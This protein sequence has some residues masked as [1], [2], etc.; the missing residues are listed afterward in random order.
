ML[1]LNAGIV[2]SCSIVIVV[3]FCSVLF[4]VCVV[5]GYCLVVVFLGDVM[6]FEVMY[7]YVGSGCRDRNYFYNYL[8]VPVYV[9]LCLS[10]FLSL[11]FLGFED[12]T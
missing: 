10:L 8:H 2:F 7:L 5:S 6:L 12:P 1:L 11:S 4:Q 3:M 9:V